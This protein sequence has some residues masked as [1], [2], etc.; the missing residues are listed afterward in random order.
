M[1]ALKMLVSLSIFY[2]SGMNGHSKRK[3]LEIFNLN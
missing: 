1:W 3:M 2:R